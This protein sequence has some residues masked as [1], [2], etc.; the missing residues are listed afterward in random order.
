MK[1]LV[2]RL[3]SK[4]DKENPDSYRKGMLFI[5]S[6]F[7]LLGIIV[8]S[9]PYIAMTGFGDSEMLYGNIFLAAIITV[10]VGV[11]TNYGYRVLIVNLINVFGHMSSIGTYDIT[12]GIFSPDYYFGFIMCAWIFLVGNKSSGLFWFAVLMLTNV[13]FY[14]AEVMGWND[15]RH[16][17]NNL[18][19]AYHLITSLMAA[20]F[21][22]LIITLYE[23]GKNK[24][25][26][27]VIAAKTELEE[28]KKELE[29]HK[30]DIISSINYARRI[31]YAVL[32]HE[33]AICRSIP[34]SFILYR[35]R[36]IVSG[37]FFWFH[38]IDEKNYIIVCA[39]C[40]GHGVPGAFMTVIGSSLLTQIV[41][42]NG[43]TKPSDI[44]AEL[45]RRIIETLK[46]EKNRT[47]QVQDGMDLSLLKV[48]KADREF[49]YTSAKRPAI[50]IRGKQL[51]E[52]KGSKLSLGGMRS[53]E[54]KFG[55]IR[56]KYEE[57]D[58]IYLFTDGYI[59]QFGGPENKKFMIK[60]FR[61]LLLRVCDLSMNEQKQQMEAAIRG[62]IG[63][64]EQTDDI[65]VIGIRF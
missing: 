4:K 54:K 40:T 61:E 30:E 45:D 65:T 51:Q 5:Y 29:A 14:Y 43:I 52:F 42:D 18:S 1:K 3:I 23:N 53:G 38:E 15:F 46:Q 64:N 26:Q 35:P 12:G 37:D 27:Q 25:V 31:Q 2:D 41:K 62:W 9:L 20:G 39:D 32:P 8:I 48:N 63:N 21:L 10:L 17:A 56:M 55:E 16:D 36:D 19:P 24:Y 50:F 6:M 44:L 34:L 33:D 57:D 59:D 7:A 11:Y 47:A 60:R 28:Q 58:M 49:I 22:A 13:F